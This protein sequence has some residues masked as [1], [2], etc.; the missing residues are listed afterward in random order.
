MN[1]AALCHAKDKHVWSYFSFPCSILLPGNNNHS[2]RKLLKDS[3]LQAPTGSLRVTMCY[4]LMSHNNGNLWFTLF[5]SLFLYLVLLRVVVLWLLTLHL[6]LSLFYSSLWARSPHFAFKAHQTPPTGSTGATPAIQEIVQHHILILTI[7][8]HS[9][10][11][12]Q[13]NNAACCCH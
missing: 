13:E 9:P 8:K 2:A 10:H 1:K 3:V 12:Y 7:Y 5:D 11:Y 4:G 6:S